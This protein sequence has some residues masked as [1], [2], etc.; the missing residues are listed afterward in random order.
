MRKFTY[1]ASLMVVTHLRHP[2]K[3]CRA[4]EAKMDEIGVGEI[5]SVSGRYYA[6]DRDNRWDRV[7]LAYKALT[8]GKA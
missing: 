4:A 3:S 2:E 8:K 7:E 5:A 6:M 1:T